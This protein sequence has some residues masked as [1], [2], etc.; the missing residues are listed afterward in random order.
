MAN[1]II[2]DRWGMQ[3]MG[4]RWQC[5]LNPSNTFSQQN[6]RGTEFSLKCSDSAHNCQHLV[7]EL[8]PPELRKDTFLMFKAILFLLI[9]HGNHRKQIQSLTLYF[10]DMFT[11]FC[12]YFLKL[13]HICLMTDYIFL[14]H[15]LN[16]YCVL[17]FTFSVL[18]CLILFKLPLHI[19]KLIPSY[20]PWSAKDL[21]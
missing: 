6:L 14:K 5:S 21:G 2:R 7:S 9:Y 19:A 3:G 13:I 1:V 12:L 16:I 4:Q 15:S 20:L 18:C 11:F 10:K 8:W 17:V